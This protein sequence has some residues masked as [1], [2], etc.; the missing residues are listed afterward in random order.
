MRSVGDLRADQRVLRAKRIGKNEIQRVTA[1]V[2][3]AVPFRRRKMAR[4]DPVILKR[5]QETAQKVND[6]LNSGSN[7]QLT[8]EQKQQI[9]EKI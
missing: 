3:V 8:D 6:F 1:D 2:V 7:N 9:K 4:R 5:F